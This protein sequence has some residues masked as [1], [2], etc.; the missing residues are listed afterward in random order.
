MGL[1][2]VR[3]GPGGPFLTGDH[4]AWNTGNTFV[5]RVFAAYEYI[6]CV[7]STSELLLAIARGEWHCGANGKSVPQYNRTDFTKSLRWKRI[8]DPPCILTLF[9]QFHS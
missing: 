6:G 8:L 3:I 7:T 5:A 9:Y 2:A 4:S 1:Q